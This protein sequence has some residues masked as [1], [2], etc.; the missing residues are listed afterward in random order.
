MAYYGAVDVGG[1]KIAVGVGDTEGTF[2]ATHVLPTDPKWDAQ[3]VVSNITE[4][5]KAVAREANIA[6]ADLRYI[7]L[8][9][10]GPLDGSILLDA[11]NIGGWKGLDW[12][13]DLEATLKRP[14]SVQNDATAAGLGEWRFG[15]GRGTQHCVYVTISTGIGAGIVADGQ[16]YRGARGN[17]GEFGHIVMRP[18]GPV[19]S[20]GHQG[21]LESLASGTA[22][23]RR[24]RERQKD[25]EYLRAQSEVE[26]KTVFEGFESDD[27]VCRAIVEEAADWLGLG[28]SYLINLFNP[29]KIILGGGVA[30]HA[31][32][33]YPER[34][35]QAAQR[36]SLKAMA[37]VVRLVPAELG[38]DSGLMGALAVAVMADSH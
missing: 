8:G 12:Q 14:V 5:V 3:T 22:I 33:A 23:A 37:E 36:W 9:S 29:E 25:S 20:A 35:W 32:E 16:L 15:A 1:T 31:P 24:G 17:A 21:C 10:P 38:G 6:V 27:A 28:L 2:Y 18:D 4:T 13:K 26:T 11:S 19:C 30:T 34:V 7:G